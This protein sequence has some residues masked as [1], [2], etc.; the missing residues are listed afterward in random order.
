MGFKGHNRIVKPRLILT[1]NEALLLEDTVWDD[2]QVSLST[3][4]LPAVNAPTWRTYNYGVVGGVQFAV[5]GFDVN[6]YLDFT[7]QSRH[8]MKL[9][10]VLKNHI[11]WTV[12]NDAAG[13][14][15]KF[16]LDVIAAP[17]ESNYAL[18]TGSPFTVEYVLVGDESG[19]HNV[20]GLGDVPGINTTVS[21]MYKCKFSRIAASASE[22]SFEAYVDYN[23]GH[24]ELDGMGSK[25]EYSK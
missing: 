19:K 6:N 12:P 3:A 25:D 13:E 18:V 22:Y 17:I 7:I 14:R 21:T 4:R 8:A 10:T 2:F 1:E 20:L 23:D 16:Q 11:H 24:Y 5:L 15:V 9:S